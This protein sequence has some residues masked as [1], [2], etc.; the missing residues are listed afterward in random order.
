MLSAPLGQCIRTWR[1]PRNSRTGR[2]LQQKVDSTVR[3]DFNVPNV[4]RAAQEH[5]R[6]KGGN[7]GPDT[8]II[9]HGRDHEAHALLFYQCF[10]PCGNL[11]I[12]LFRKAGLPTSNASSAYGDKGMNRAFR[13][14]FALDRN[15]SRTCRIKEGFRHLTFEILD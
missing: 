13:R 7:P 12:A 5:F 9:P 2:A 14:I 10:D 8:G 1:E 6:K 15:N 3:S 4:C 11:G